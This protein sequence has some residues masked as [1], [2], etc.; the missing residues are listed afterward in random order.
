MWA[1]TFSS[2]KNPC[3]KHTDAYRGL[4]V[5]PV[6]LA[7]TGPDSTSVPYLYLF[8]KKINYTNILNIF[9]LH[10]VCAV[11]FFLHSIYFL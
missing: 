2:L 8:L 6:Y 1:V 10:S 4:K 11:N 5:A 3:R 9:Q 7:R